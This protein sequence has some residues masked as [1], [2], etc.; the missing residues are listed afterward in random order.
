MFQISDGC[1]PRSRLHQT[2]PGL[3]PASNSS[4]V[5]KCCC[6]LPAAKR[7]VTKDSASKGKRFWTCGD[8]RTCDFFEWIDT[9]SL[10]FP[11]GDTTQTSSA[12]KV[13]PA[14]RLYPRYSVRFIMYMCLWANTRLR[15]IRGRVLL[16]RK[17]NLQD[18]V[19]VT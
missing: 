3:R 15:R 11:S 18:V 6:N 13:V 16:P 8:N 14:K 7:T 17:M 5:V 4:T 12:A 9:T 2:G 19:N 1:P 10:S